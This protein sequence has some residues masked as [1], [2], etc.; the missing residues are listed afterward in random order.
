MS[1]LPDVSDGTFDKEVLESKGPAVVDFWA[2]WCGPCQMA[3]P[4]VEELAKEYDGKVGFYKLNV[5]DNQAVAGRYG[6]HSIPTLM[7]F[8]A[9][10]PVGTVVG[11][12][13]K[14][15]LKKKIDGALSNPGGS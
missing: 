5:D 11:F 7:I 13:P 2:P 9:G 8:D 12:V 14:P 10:K 3:G 6:I 1:S 4:I 15:E